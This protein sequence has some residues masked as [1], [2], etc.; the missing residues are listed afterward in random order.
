MNK[1]SLIII[2][3][4][5]GVVVIL[6]FLF[7][8]SPDGS[9]QN[10]VSF[11]NPEGNVAAEIPF[12]DVAQVEIEE[13]DDNSN[14][15]THPQYGFSLEYPKNMTTSN[16]IEGVGEQILFQNN[17]EDQW[18]QVYITPWDE[19][20]GLSVER[21]KQDLPN[22]LI[23]EPQE[24]ILGPEQKAGVGVRALI[25]FGEE[26]GIGET[27]EVWFVHQNNLYQITT[28]R[29]LDSFL[30]EILSTLTF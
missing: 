19:P 18:F 29:R 24:V 2:L 12:S 5:I 17:E 16:F 1:R 25:F 15:F 6:S 13:V 20:T 9:F 3:I 27:R 4:I 11:L 30:A 26:D 21:I 22:L 28:Y 7:F 23:E 8:R 14:N 10:P